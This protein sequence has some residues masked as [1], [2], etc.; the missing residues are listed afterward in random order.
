MDKLL[1]FPR[2]TGGIVAE[3]GLNNPLLAIFVP[4]LGFVDAGGLS[5]AGALVRKYFVQ[6]ETAS[7][8]VFFHM[9]NDHI[10]LA[11]Q[12]AVARHQLQIL[13]KGQIVK[14]GP[15]HLTPLEFYRGKDS[16]RCNLSSPSR[17]PLNGTK[18]CF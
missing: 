13:N 5:A 6:T 14:A 3:Q 18:R 8:D 9:R 17:R 1:E 4:S 15:R 10:P 7:V 12:N 16:H 11:D 2:L